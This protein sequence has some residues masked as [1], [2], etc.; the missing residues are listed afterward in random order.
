MLLFEQRRVLLD[1]CFREPRWRSHSRSGP[2][3][4]TPL[5]RLLKY[6][7]SGNAGPASGQQRGKKL[8]AV[9]ILSG[10]LVPILVLLII[11]Q[12]ISLD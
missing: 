1:L 12:L 9:R 4:G 6:S 5:R 7:R 3:M 11:C 10:S 8:F 2:E